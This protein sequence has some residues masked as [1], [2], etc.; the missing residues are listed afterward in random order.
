MSTGCNRLLDDS[1]GYDGESRVDEDCFES[2]P[3]PAKAQV[4]AIGSE[5]GNSDSADT[6]QLNLQA[7]GLVFQMQTRSNLNPVVVEL[8]AK[9]AVALERIKVMDAQLT[10]SIYRVGYLEAI[11]TERERQ[12]K[13]MATARKRLIK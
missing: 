13:Q 11:L 1:L 6:V 3:T 7:Q 4:L 5:L 2:S 8:T 12:I 9:L 10:Q